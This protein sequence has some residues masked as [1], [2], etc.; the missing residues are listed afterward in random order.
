MLCIACCPGGWT[1]STMP[2][3]KAWSWTRDADAAHRELL[4]GLLDDRL[5]D[6]LRSG[7]DAAGMPVRQ[8]TATSWSELRSGRSRDC[9]HLEFISP[10]T[11]RRGNR[12]LPWLSPSAVF[13][14]PAGRVAT[15]RCTRGGGPRAGPEPRPAG[16]HGRVWCQPHRARHRP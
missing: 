8:V 11:F 7:A 5:A 15:L 1:V 2:S 16:R 12:F 6:R 13:R 14:R 3:T 9:W 10:V 4:I